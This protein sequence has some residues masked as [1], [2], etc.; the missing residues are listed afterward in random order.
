[1]VV[2][3]NRGQKWKGHVTNMKFAK[4]EAPNIEEWVFMAVWILGKFKEFISKILLVSKT[5]S[6]VTFFHT[7]LCNFLKIQTPIKIHSL[8]PGA[9]N[10][11]VLLLSERSFHF[12]F[13]FCATTIFYDWQGHVTPSCK[14][15]IQLRQN[16]VS[17]RDDSFW[18]CHNDF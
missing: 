6:P 15:P 4:F 7:N 11:A 18:L 3:Q 10:L 5:C 9:L 1:M 8:M 16:T 2:V 14:E 13:P 17:Q 12:W